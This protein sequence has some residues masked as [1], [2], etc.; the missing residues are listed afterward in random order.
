MAE[1]AASGF[2]FMFVVCDTFD[3]QQY[4]V[5]VKASEFWS[6]HERYHGMDMQR[7]EGYYDLS[8]KQTLINFPPKVEPEAY[9]LTLLKARPTHTT[10]TVHMDYQR[11]KLT[12]IDTT[13]RQAL[14]QVREA[15]LDP[16][17]PHVASRANNALNIIDK[18]IGEPK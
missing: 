10:F 2:Q 4:P 12:E 7:I 15:L 8:T 1:K 11:R 17:N 6:M 5:G 14:E 3:Y 18:V 16:Q 9:M 13:E